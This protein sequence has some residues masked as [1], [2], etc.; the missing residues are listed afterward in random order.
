MSLGCSWAISSASLLRDLS[1]TISTLFKYPRIIM[2][3]LYYIGLD[4]HKESVAIAYIP[5]HSRAEAS[6]LTTCGGSNL[7]VERA[8]RKL[9]K[10]L[11]QTLQDLKVCYEAGPTGF[12]LGRRLIALGIDCVLCSPSHNERKPGEAI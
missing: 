6:Y 4:V 9:A 11:G 7:A 8:L 5:A 3:P 10:S 12:V 2:K 1:N